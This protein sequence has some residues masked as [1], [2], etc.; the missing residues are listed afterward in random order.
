MSDDTPAIEAP[1]SL[2]QISAFDADARENPHPKLKA[3]RET[4]PV[5]RDEAVKTWLLTRYDDIRATVNDRTFVRQPSKAEEGSM[6]RMFANPDDPDGRRSS[7]L[8]QDDPDHSRNRLPLVKA[9]YARIKKMEPEIEVMIDQI[10]EAAPASGR[11]DLMEHIAVPIPILIIAHILG[12]DE[13]RL[14]EFRDWSEGVIL[15]LNPMRTPEETAYMEASG[16]KLDAYF[17]ELMAARRQDPKDDLISDMVQAQADGGEFDDDELRVNLQALLVGGN[18][19]TTDLIGNGVWLFLNHPDQLAA[20]KSD[21]SLGAAAVEEVL[22]YEA[23]V[24]ATSRI[25]SEDR[26]VAGCQMKKSQPVFM[27]LAAANRDPGKFD[28]PDAFDITVKR[29]SHVSFGGGAHICIGAPLA[30]IEARRVYLKLFERYPD[31]KLPDQE[32][33]WRSLPFFRGIERLDVEV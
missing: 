7:I 11:F 9:F 12:V 19:T 25:V 16:E 15:S 5:L 18:L 2:F 14:P 28:A 4:C 3:L 32:I 27:S 22:R 29:S 21:P 26:E 10:I 13:S 20:L 23:P 1:T 30:R 33:E 17:T 24:Q 6:S 31:M 8:F